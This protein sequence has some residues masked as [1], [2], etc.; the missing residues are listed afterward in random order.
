M[1]KKK[2]YIAPCIR[3]INAEFECH[4]MGSSVGGDLHNGDDDV[5]DPGGYQSRKMEFWE[6]S[7]ED[8]YIGE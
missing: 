6:F 4:I 5:E 7:W 3:I 2:L 1:N 8:N